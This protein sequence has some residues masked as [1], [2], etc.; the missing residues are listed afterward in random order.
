MGRMEH[1][2][3]VIFGDKNIGG[4][5]VINAGVVKAHDETAERRFP[6]V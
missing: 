2:S 6:A 4:F 5:Q 3:K 1:A